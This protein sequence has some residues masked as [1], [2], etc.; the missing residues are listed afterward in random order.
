MHASVPFDVENREVNAAP[1]NLV[2][3]TGKERASFVVASPSATA[4]GSMRQLG[5]KKRQKP[6]P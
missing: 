2:W 6:Q 3:A 1:V 4:G 5:A